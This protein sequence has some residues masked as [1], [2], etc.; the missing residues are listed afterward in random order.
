M[1]KSFLVILIMVVFLTSCG[2]LQDGKKDTEAA[3]GATVD[4]AEEGVSVQ[5]KEEPAPEQA[6]EATSANEETDAA[7]DSN[8]VHT[9]QVMIADNCLEEW[10][11]SEDGSWDETITKL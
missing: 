7:E 1:K 5:E 3:K 10:S 11:Q 4:L 6:S 8:N 2:R 9:L